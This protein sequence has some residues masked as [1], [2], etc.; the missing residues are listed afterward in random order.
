MFS[1]QIGAMH[2]ANGGRDK[3]KTPFRLIDVMALQD[4]MT[5]QNLIL[6]VLPGGSQVEQKNW[7]IGTFWRSATDLSLYIICCSCLRSWIKQCRR[8]FFFFR[9]IKIS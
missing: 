8:F 7:L 9:R 6:P 4:V 5:K 2:K 1:K 3:K